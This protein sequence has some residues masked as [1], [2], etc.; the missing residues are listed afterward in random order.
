MRR[1]YR[2]VD[3]LRHRSKVV[4]SRSERLTLK[5]RKRMF[6]VRMANVH[7]RKIA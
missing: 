6:A 1:V 2:H 5:A 7:R 3:T 4:E